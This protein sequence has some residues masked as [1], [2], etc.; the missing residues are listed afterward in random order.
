MA[1]ALVQ[2]PSPIVLSSVEIENRIK[3][4]GVPLPKSATLLNY[5]Y[6]AGRDFHCWIGYSAPKHDIE[7]AIATF[8]ASRRSKEKMSYGF[9]ERPIIRKRGTEVGE[10]QTWWPLPKDSSL[11]QY[12]GA[13]FWIGFDEAAERVFFFIYSI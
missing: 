2:T 8:L 1:K 7:K 10:P 3:N 5:H 4:Q 9:P 13:F 12:E 6:Q 11:T